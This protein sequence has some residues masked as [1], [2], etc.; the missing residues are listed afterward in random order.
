MTKKVA[1]EAKQEEAKEEAP[2]QPQLEMP[3]LL[4]GLEGAPSPDQIEQWKAEFGDVY[5]SGFSETELFVWRPL[6][7][8]EFVQ[9]QATVAEKQLDQYQ[10]EE[11]VCATCV[12]WPEADWSK[13]KAGNASTVHEQIMQNSN[14]LAP[15]A[16]AFLVAKL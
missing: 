8:G 12:L 1:E 4:Q 15:Q 2:A 5:V 10:S 16:A 9:L 6:F 11:L 3:T 7:R 13:S 14:F